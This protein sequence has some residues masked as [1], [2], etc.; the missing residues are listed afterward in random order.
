MN[1]TQ[2]YDRINQ[3]IRKLE[4]F[5]E[6]L[7]LTIVYF[8]T[9]K[10]YYRELET[11]A[12]LGRGKYVLMLLYF[13][14]LL[15][16][17]LLLECFKFGHNKFPEIFISQWISLII[18]NA[19]TYFIL[20]LIGNRMLNV[21]AIAVMTLIDFA[22]AFLL[23]YIFTIIYHKLHPP[24]QMLMI[25]GSEEAVDLKFKMDQ[26]ADKY[27]VARIIDVSELVD[28]DYSAF[29]EYDGIII[30]DVSAE[31]RND[32]LKYCYN[33]KIRAYVV[34]KI[35]DIILGGSEEITLFDT[36]LFL[37]RDA[38]LSLSQRFVKRLLD[39]V[40]CFIA[41]IPGSIIMG[42]VALAI[43]LDDRGAVFYRQERVTLD[44]KIFNII[45]FRSM[46]EN[47]EENGQVIPATGKDPRI[48]RVGK[49]IR[50]MRLDEIPQLFNIIK[51]DMSI[52]GPRPE[53]VEHVKEYTAQ[54]PEFAFRTKVKGGLTGYAQVYGKY[55]TT[56]YDKLRLDL[57][58]IANYSITLD[59]KLIIMTVLALFK[60]EST[61]GFDAIEERESKR[62]E[63]LNSFY[64][65]S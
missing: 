56:A 15:I 42:V 29:K 50:A 22:I 33:E 64:E 23:S 37:V 13:S 11:R 14:L 6:L 10:G 8:F 61:E 9:W 45:K 48:T 2:K 57:L 28:M 16:L 4:G 5:A 40:L 51:G 12:F 7:I 49:V 53:R 25:F 20:C 39:L 54:I 17:F 26:R 58:Y 18:V 3:F 21:W 62:D 65:D 31:L 60:K 30:N 27:H 63:L 35:T 1:K 19:F 24:R 59:I 44:G 47:A 36:P 32:I 52:V 46:I 55:N 43:K 41:L 34:P 38:A